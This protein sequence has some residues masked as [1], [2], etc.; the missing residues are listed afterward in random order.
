MAFRRVFRKV[1][2]LTRSLLLRIAAALS[3]TTAVGHT[4]GTFMP[5]P[6]EQVQVH[7]TIVTMKS[8]LVPIPVGTAQ[9]HGDS[10]RQQHLH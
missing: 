1:R 9:L 4:I 7:A 8:T 3:L 5:V 10:G 2:Q 6:K